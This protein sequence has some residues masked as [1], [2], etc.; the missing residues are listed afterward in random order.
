MQR[1]TYRVTLRILEPPIKTNGP[2][3]IKCNINTNSNTNKNDVLIS[4]R[5]SALLGSGIHYK[6]TN[7]FL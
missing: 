1:E 2:S 4:P 5:N 7:P 3:L 6:E